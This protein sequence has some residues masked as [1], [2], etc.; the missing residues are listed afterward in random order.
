MMA[1]PNE[2]LRRS[3]VSVRAWNVIH[4]ELLKVPWFEELPK[5]ARPIKL[6]E[7]TAYTKRDWL[8]VKNCGRVTANEIATLLG[9]HDLSFGEP[10]PY[11]RFDPRPRCAECLQV[12]VSAYALERARRAGGEK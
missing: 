7:L 9:R 3:E 4:H 2:V 11:D 6:V 10:R 12:L 5:D 8:E 1:D